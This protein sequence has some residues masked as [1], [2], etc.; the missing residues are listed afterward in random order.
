MAAIEVKVNQASPRAESEG[1]SAEVKG[2]KRAE[3]C[4][5]DWLTEMALEGRAFQVRAGTITTPVAGDI[6]ITDGAS[7]MCVDA[8][9]GLTIIPVYLNINLEAL[10]GGTLPECAAKSV[11]SASTA[12]TVFVP[13]P[14]FMGGIASQ[15]TAR[16]Q[17]VGEVLVGAELATTTRVHFVNSVAA[18]ADRILA[19]VSFRV[20]PVLKGIACFYVQIAGVTAGPTYFA[21]FDYV[22]LQTV[23]IS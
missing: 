1:V 20:P 14:L 5:M 22:E 6:A 23:T 15:A 4:V 18:V 3:L 21:H 11:G 13:L 2:T 9:S 19:D 16:V 12:G 10:G 17:A 7:E 8:A